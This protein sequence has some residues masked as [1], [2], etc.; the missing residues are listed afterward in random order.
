[1]GFVEFNIKVAISEKYYILIGRIRNKFVS[2]FGSSII[3]G[4]DNI[5]HGID[6]LRNAFRK[7]LQPS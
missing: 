5:W 1:V 4:E 2:D 7:D 6:Y 3:Y